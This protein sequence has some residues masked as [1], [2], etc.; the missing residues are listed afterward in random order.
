MVARSMEARP[1]GRCLR[2]GRPHFFPKKWGERRAG[3]AP[4]TLDPPVRGF[5]AAESC[6]DKAR[7]GRASTP[8]SFLCPSQALPRPGRPASITR[9]ALTAA[10]L[11]RSGPPGRHRCYAAEILWRLR[12]HTACLGPTSPVGGGRAPTAR[13]ESA[14]GRA[15]RATTRAGRLL[16][17]SGPHRRKE[18]TMK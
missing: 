3:G 2:G 5:M 9:Q 16:L 13:F 7:T 4:P 10:A 15:V 17:T 12:R 18:D 6:T 8:G 14:A 11:Y 1:P